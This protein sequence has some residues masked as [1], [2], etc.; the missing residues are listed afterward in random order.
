M[1]ISQD[2]GCEPFTGRRI[3]IKGESRQTLLSLKPKI[4]KDVDFVG[5][6]LGSVYDC[7]SK[8]KLRT[9]NRF[10]VNCYHLPDSDS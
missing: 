1:I 9:R 4:G 5:K 2:T 6:T 8:V 3:L 10:F 7:K